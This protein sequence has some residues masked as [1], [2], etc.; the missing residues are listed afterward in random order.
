MI[1]QRGETG[2]SFAYAGD[3]LGG[4]VGLHLLLAAGLLLGAV[5]RTSTPAV[6]LA[7]GSRIA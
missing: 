5:R 1:E 4:A 6:R 7:R 3:S 2:G